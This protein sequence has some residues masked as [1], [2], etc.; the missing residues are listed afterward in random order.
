MKI[1]Y[2][3][4]WVN[5]NS[6]DLVIRNHHLQLYDPKKAHK[7]VDVKILDPLALSSLL[8]EFDFL[9]RR[10]KSRPKLLCY[11]NCFNHGTEGENEKRDKRS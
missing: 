2:E 5:L 8:V 11:K 3:I 7:L 10:C 4:C 9:E 6:K 1:A